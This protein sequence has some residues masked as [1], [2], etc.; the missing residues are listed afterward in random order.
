M[1]DQPFN[2]NS[3]DNSKDDKQLQKATQPVAINTGGQAL[4]GSQQGKVASFS[5]GQT[6]TQGSGR[7]TNIQKYMDANKQA[8]GNLGAKANQQIGQQFSKQEQEVGQKNASL[9]KAFGQGE[10][11]LSTGQGFQQQLGNIQQG[12]Q[13]GFTDFGNR[14]GFDTAGQQAM[15][16]AQNQDYGRIASGQ[17]INEQALAAQ[18]Q[19]A[20]MGAQ[21]LQKTAAQ[22]LQG[23]ETEQGR[24][25]LFSQVLQPKQGYTAG[26][27]AFDKLFLGGAL[28]GIKQTLQGQQAG[29]ADL[30]GRTAGQQTTLEDL[31]KREAALTSG[32]TTAAKTAQDL[33]NEKLGAQSNIDYINKLREDRYNKFITDLQAGNISNADLDLTGLQNTNTYIN[34]NQPIGSGTGPTATVQKNLIGTYNTLTDPNKAK[35][36]FTQGQGASSFQDIVAQPDY[37]VYKA[38]QNLAL[39]RDTG[40]LSGV[41]QL[42]SSVTNTGKLAEDIAAADKAFRDQYAGKNFAGSGLSSTGYFTSHSNSGFG[43]APSQLQQDYTGTGGSGIG[44]TYDFNN[45]S[46][47]LL[48]NLNNYRDPYGRAATAV[49][50]ASAVNNTNIDDYIRN[51]QLASTQTGNN[52]GKVIDRGFKRSVNDEDISNARARAEANVRNL[53]NQT[54]SSTG[55]KN[56]LNVTNEE[57]VVPKRFSGLV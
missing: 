55:V 14:E 45:V 3:D 39:G 16:L 5:S 21:G 27:R 11:E 47:Q 8:S 49:S 13:T 19:A 25:K 46:N 1:V 12:L 17:A 37:D 4:P 53:L 44:S 43:G 56:A 38:L 50:G 57:P 2:G 22:N 23:I 48:N 26:Q 15:Q 10:Q 33:F 41:S 30:L 42:S 24:D 52:G 40:A 20:L 54:I 31:T 9:Q 35:Q 6:P 7:F 51:S 32:I 34:E 18:Q 29:A 28:G 36:Y